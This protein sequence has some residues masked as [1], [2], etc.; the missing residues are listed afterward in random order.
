MLS[1]RVVGH[2]ADSVAEGLLEV[3]DVLLVGG[4]D[5]VDLGWKVLGLEAQVLWQGE[6]TLGHVRQLV[7]AHG[8]EGLLLERALGLGVDTEEVQVGAGEC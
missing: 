5:L 4:G 8:L 1:Q 7:L 3:L 2:A 6:H